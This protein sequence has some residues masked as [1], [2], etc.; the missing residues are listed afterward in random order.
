MHSDS[1]K[2]AKECG[3]TGNI[4]IQLDNL[5]ITALE[6]GEYDSALSYHYQALG[7]NESILIIKEALSIN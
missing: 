5:G 4:I 2:I 6:I 7:V 3:H 1:L